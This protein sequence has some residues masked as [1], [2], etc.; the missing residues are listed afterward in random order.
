MSILFGPVVKILTF[1]DVDLMDIC[2][3]Y[4]SGYPTT[5]S[6]F[7]SYKNYNDPYLPPNMSPY[8][9][10]KMGQIS[11][12][13]HTTDVDPQFGNGWA[14]LT[15]S[16]V[17]TVTEVNTLKFTYP[18]LSILIPKQP[19]IDQGFHTSYCWRT[20]DGKATE[21]IFRYNMEITILQQDGSIR[22][23]LKE[24]RISAAPLMLARR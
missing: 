13:T 23:N 21:P 20:S 14:S 18:I 24:Y 12:V 9:T 16:H 1:E 5:I 2:N 7:Y 4:N 15:S 11:D 8:E 6:A 19:W 10:I 3:K 22:S 17:N